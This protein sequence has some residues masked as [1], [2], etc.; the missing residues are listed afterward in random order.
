[1]KTKK[2]KCVRKTDILDKLLKNSKD[3]PAWCS[4]IVDKNFWNL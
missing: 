2:N 3:M 4:G 1:M